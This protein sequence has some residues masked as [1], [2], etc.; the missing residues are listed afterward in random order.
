MMKKRLLGLVLT[1]SVLLSV[2]GFTYAESASQVTPDINAAINVATSYLEESAYARYFYE[3]RD[4]EQFTIASIPETEQASLSQSIANYPAF[5]NAQE[6]VPYEETN[7][8]TGTLL[9]LTENL[10]LH[11]KSVAFY[12][13]INEMEGITYKYFSPSYEVVDNS[14]DGNLA[15]VNVYET[16]D[17]QYSDCDEPSM[18]ITHYFVSLVKHD[19]N[20]LVMAV[21]SD[22][23][24]YQIYRESGFDLQA[25]IADVDAAYM[26]NDEF[27]AEVSSSSV[28]DAT[29]TAPLAASN[30]DRTYIPQ[31]AVNYALTYSTSGDDGNKTPS[32][33]NTKFYWTS[34]SCQLFVSQCL[35]AGFGGSNS[36][37]DIN[38]KLGMDTSGSYQWW[39]TK[40]LYNNPEYNDPGSLSDKGWNSWVKCSQFKVYVDAVK[41]STTESGIVCD[42]YEVPC[43]SEDMV[44]TSGLTK[45]DLI[46][47]ALHV[48]GADS[49]G[50]PVALGH[51]VIVN[52]A[53]GTT[54]STV[55]YTSY[56][57]CAKNIK[58]STGFPAG[59]A[60]VNKIYVMVPRYLRGGNG[61][62]T[63]YLYGD[64]QNA[65]VKGTSGITKTL[66]GRANSAVTT[67]TMK[68]YAPNASTASYTFTA[69]N[70]KVVSGSVLFNKAGDWTVVVSGTGLND[71]TYQVRVV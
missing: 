11:Q 21:E 51:A 36:Q 43:N 19:D 2:T 17:F 61:A 55:Y 49:A 5:R 68:V 59:S 69:S 24:F 7:I 41:A 40:T 66:Y 20:W 32:Y 1:L 50:N 9:P 4:T 26:R 57:N 31:N 8:T 62:T 28:K 39:S 22:D 71:F 3:A 60:S 70:K 63:N 27:A 34:S 46:G 25:E 14:I 56:N 67:L 6:I 64:L 54:R 44:G 30:T 33:K 42:T 48:K 52:N 23:L 35:W 58:V 47:A 15:T 13:H 10:S 12:G 53:T 37:T 45:S 38:N 65:L 29:Q 18:M 16:L